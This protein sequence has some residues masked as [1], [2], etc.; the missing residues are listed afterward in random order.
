MNT[1]IW[2]KVFRKNEEIVSREIAGE[3]ILVPI[4]G[5]LTDLQRIFS[6]NPVAKFIW[7]GIDGRR[8]VGEIRN[9]VLTNF[10]VEE[11][12][13]DVDIR[14]FIDELSAEDLIIGVK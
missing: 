9:E 12:T 8:N 14:E 4:R 3:V 2:G 1:E 11:E 6:L 7:H 10:D 13:A 5:T